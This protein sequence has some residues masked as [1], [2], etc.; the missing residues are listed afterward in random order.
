MNGFVIRRNSDG[1][2]VAKPGRKSSYT[3]YLQAARVFKT[4]VDAESDRCVENESIQSIE[5]CFR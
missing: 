2:F 4:R 5:E 3:M 1:R